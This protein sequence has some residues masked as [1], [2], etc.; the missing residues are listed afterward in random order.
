VGHALAVT[1]QI[2]EGALGGLLMVRASAI[3]T[4]VGPTLTSQAVAVLRHQVD[5]VAQSRACLG[6]ISSQRMKAGAS[7]LIKFMHRAGAHT[8]HLHTSS[9]ATAGHTASV[10]LSK[11]V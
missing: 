1:A 5:G 6:S 11:T 3:R 4:S 2:G 7:P 10:G 9:F 8:E